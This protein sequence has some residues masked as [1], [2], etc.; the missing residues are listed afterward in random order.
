MTTAL[1]RVVPLAG[2]IDLRATLSPLARG[3]HDPCVQ[4]GPREFWRATH[5]PDGPGTQHLRAAAGGVE[6]AAYGP[7]AA[8][9]VEHAPALVGAGDTGHEFEPTDAFVAELH[10]RDRGL[11]L[12]AA[13]NPVELMVPTV[14]EQKVTSTEAHRAYAR[15]VRAHGCPAPGPNAALRLPPTVAELT[16]LPSFAWHAVGV[17]RRRAETV[18]EVCT[19][20]ASI[21]RVAAGGSAD[22]QRAVT[23]LRGVGPWTAT[24]VAGIA[25]GDPDAVVVGDYHLPSIV[26]WNLVGERQADDARMLELLEPFRPHRARVV[27]LL[28]RAGGHPPRRAPRR[29]LRDIRRI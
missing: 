29:A 11:R 10:R 5:T 8:W 25:F 7:G 9:L 2:P 12:T 16:A 17:E 18:R 26:A 1:R 28:A 24:S 14:L 22:F 19:R 20:A 13:G 23:S 6:V 15:L 21:E 3:P 27:A 4:R